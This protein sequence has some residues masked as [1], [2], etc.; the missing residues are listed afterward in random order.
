MNKDIKRITAVEFLVLFIMFGCFAA[1]LYFVIQTNK[2]YSLIFFALHGILA[3]V[4]IFINQ[5]RITKVMLDASEKNTEFLGIEQEMKMGNI[6]K[7]KKENEELKEKAHRLDAD[8]SKLDDEKRQL[9]LR[10]AEREAALS[11]AKNSEQYNMLLPENEHTSNTNIIAIINKVFE[12]FEEP[13]CKSGIRLGLSTTYSELL[14]TC[15]ER[16][17]IVMFSN[18][19]DNSIKYMNRNGSFI[20]TVSDIGEEGIF[21]VCKDNGEGLPAAEVPYIF[22]LNFQG[23]NRKSGNGLGLA[24]VKAV[25]EHYNG[26]VYAKSDVGEGMAVYIQF[27]SSDKR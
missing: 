1:A 27:P 19:I 3:I 9:A 15:D 6:E 21:I 14:M 8:I 16:F 25:V 17:L 4:Y 22:G 5:D 7:L 24:Q 12:K 23:S 18:I 11:Y 10:L 2:M 13:C 26:I 20:I